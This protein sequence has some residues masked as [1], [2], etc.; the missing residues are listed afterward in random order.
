M[1]NFKFHIH[2]AA[3]PISH[4]LCYTYIAV[5]LPGLCIPTSVVIYDAK[6]SHPLEV[7]GLTY[8]GIYPDWLQQICIITCSVFVSQI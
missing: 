8:Q 1:L 6:G 2:I 5:I 3:A 7:Y 4:N